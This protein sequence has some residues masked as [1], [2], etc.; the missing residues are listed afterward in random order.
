MIGWY[1]DAGK[2]WNKMVIG[3]I[4]TY[5]PDTARARAQEL[6]R[7][8]AEGNNP[9]HQRAAKAAAPTFQDLLTDYRAGELQEKEASTIKSYE[10]RIRRILLPAFKTVKVADID[11]E[12]IDA[13]RRKHRKTPTELNRAF[14]TGSRMM[15]LAVRKG[16]ITHNPFRGAERFPENQR[17]E[18]L[19]EHDLPKFLAELSKV[20]KPVG[21][22]IRFMACTGWRISVARLLRWDQVDLQRLTVSLKQSTTK[23]AARALAADA[24]TIIDRQGHRLGFVFSNTAGRA[25][26]TDRTVRDELKRLCKAAGIPAIR[27][28]TLRHS[29]A[30]WSAING[31]SAFELQQSIGWRTLAMAQRYVSKSQSLS[32][33]GAEKTAAAINVLGKPTA[34]V[35]Q[36]PVKQRDS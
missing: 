3:D 35:V 23:K 33:S 20:E 4:G 6:L 2:K 7:A 30:T 24:A 25:A 16:W 28:H 14:A 26:I 36:L 15:T 8:V 18:W 29:A 19:D 27:P 1:T 17:D 21:D 32:R 13:L 5:E 10:A 11:A 12:M 34:E 22:L 31:A 9:K